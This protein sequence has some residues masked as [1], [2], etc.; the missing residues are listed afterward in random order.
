[1]SCVSR[2]PGIWVSLLPT[3]TPVTAQHVSWGPVTL[4]GA[5]RGTGWEGG[6]LHTANPQ[7]GWIQKQGPKAPPKHLLCHL[8]QPQEQPGGRQLQDPCMVC[9]SHRSLQSP[10]WEPSDALGDRNTPKLQRLDFP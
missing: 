1:M 9:G 4:D 3:I 5:M 6:F 8:S 10:P 2:A 7:Q